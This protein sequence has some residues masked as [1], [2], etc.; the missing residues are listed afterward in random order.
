MFEPGENMR[1][2]VVTVR[3]LAFGRERSET[4]RVRNVK[5]RENSILACNFEVGDPGARLNVS[6]VESDILEGW[7]D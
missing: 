2:M 6:G 5:A 1:F 4:V 3:P 7:G